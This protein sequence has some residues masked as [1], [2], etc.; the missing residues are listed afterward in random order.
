MER[1]ERGRRGS[2][3]DRNIESV[4]THQ[5]EITRRV[6]EPALLLFERGVVLF[7]DDDETE[8]GDRG[9]DGGASTDHELCAAAMRRSP[10][11]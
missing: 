4:R 7:I 2:E 3:H 6:S 1:F 11:R 10:S 9:K 8:I 5:S